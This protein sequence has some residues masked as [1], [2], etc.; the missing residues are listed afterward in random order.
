[1][2]ADCVAALVADQV[3]LDEPWFRIVPLRP[4]ADRDLRLEQRPR[5][6]VAATS[7]LVFLPFRSQAPVDGGCGHPHQ[8]RGGL[9]VD[10]QLPEVA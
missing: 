1:M 9:V 7:Q 8:Q 6:G 2:I 5:F 10:V 3:D 4:G